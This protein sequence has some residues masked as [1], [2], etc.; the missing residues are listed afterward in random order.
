MGHA[1]YRWWLIFHNH[2]LHD[3]HSKLKIQKEILHSRI[4][5]LLL[6]HVIWNARWLWKKNW[7]KKIPLSLSLPH[8]IIRSLSFPSRLSL[9]LSECSPI[10]GGAWIVRSAS[11]TRFDF[12]PLFLFMPDFIHWIPFSIFSFQWV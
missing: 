10:H 4:F 9:S 12:S 1:K 5:T 8:S 11:S 7:N 3:K 6:R 2:H